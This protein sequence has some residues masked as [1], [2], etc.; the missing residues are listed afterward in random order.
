MHEANS[1][2]GVNFNRDAPGFGQFALPS[3]TGSGPVAKRPGFLLLLLQL[4]P[5]FS[6]CDRPFPPKTALPA[7]RSA[8]IPE[9]RSQAR[10]TH[11]A[12]LEG[13]IRCAAFEYQGAPT[14]DLL[15]LIPE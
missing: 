8:A 11:W 12:R 5:E 15:R 2:F 10:A 9:R 1:S 14:S 13:Q 3:T 7:L 6:G 4:R